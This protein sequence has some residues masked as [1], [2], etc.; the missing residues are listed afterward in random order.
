MRIKLF[1]P[2]CFTRD[3]SRKSSAVVGEKNHYVYILLFF[4]LKVKIIMK[5]VKIAALKNAIDLM[6]RSQSFFVNDD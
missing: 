5:I 6:I 2:D 3:I 4:F 1:W